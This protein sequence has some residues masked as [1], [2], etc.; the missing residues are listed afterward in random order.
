MFENREKTADF[1]QNMT[2]E[3]LQCLF[4]NFGPR[5]ARLRSYKTLKFYLDVSQV[6]R[7][8]QEMAMEEII[9]GIGD[10]GSD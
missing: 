2:K 3:E 6:Q 7:R 10:N 8:L 5:D 9:L 4:N 1:I